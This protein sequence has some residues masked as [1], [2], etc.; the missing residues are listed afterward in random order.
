LNASIKWSGRNT[1]GTPAFASLAIA[2]ACFM[3][4][5][6]TIWGFGVTVYIKDQ[7]GFFES[8]RKF[9]RSF[10]MFSRSFYKTF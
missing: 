3:P 8:S 6:V 5:F 10:R 1:A 2:K 4:V 7:W 9:S